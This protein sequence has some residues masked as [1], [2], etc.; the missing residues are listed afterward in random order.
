MWRIIQNVIPA[1][2]VVLVLSQ[3]VIPI[4][5]DKRTLLEYL[6]LLNNIKKLPVIG[7]WFTLEIS[8][9]EITLTIAHTFSELENNQ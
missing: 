7:G 3:Y 5:F 4:L 9:K 2:L 1:L 8:R 6:L